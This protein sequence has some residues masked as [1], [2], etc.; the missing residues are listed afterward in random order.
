[1]SVGFRISHLEPGDGLGGGARDLDQE[2]VAVVDAQG[3]AGGVD[4]RTPLDPLQMCVG[5][6]W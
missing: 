5:V 2:L 6:R 3:G 4:C 1:M